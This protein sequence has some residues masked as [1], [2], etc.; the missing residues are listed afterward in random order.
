MT[1]KKNKLL[2]STDT[3]SW[4][5]LDLVF[6][7]AKNAK[8]DGIDLAIWKNFDAWNPDYV[9]KLSDKHDLPVHVIQTSGQVNEKELNLALDLCEA[10]GANTITI[11]APK[12]IDFKAHSFLI[13]NLPNYKK[14]NPD[15]N[16]SIINPP[17]SNIFALP[18]PKYYF[19]NIVE[20]IKKQWCYLGFDV[21]NLDEEALENDF[22][23][24]VDQFVPYISTIYFSDTTKTGKTHVLPWE[25]VLKIPTLLKKLKKNKYARYFSLKIDIEKSD[26]ADSDKI[27]IMLKKA[28]EYYTEHFIELDID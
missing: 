6:E 2:L 17:D 13:D 21:S 5:G 18:I 16:F 25:W 1:N 19:V 12:I 4:Y 7:T 26:L 23:R 20:I 27:D 8:F 9:K 24:K 15:I 14:D 3:L 28:K 11:N 22:M 10:T